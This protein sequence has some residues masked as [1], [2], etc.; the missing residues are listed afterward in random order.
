MGCNG[1]G[2]RNGDGQTVMDLCKNYELKILNTYF[3]KS[4]EK[5]ITY[6]SGGCETQIDL[7]LMRKSEDVK[8]VNCNAIP[9]EACVTQHRMV[10]AELVMKNMKRRKG[11]GHKHIKTWN[12]KNEETRE[13]E[14]KFSRVKKLREVFCKIVD[15]AK[16]PEEWRNSTT[17]PLF[18][19][20]RDA[21][22][23]EAYRG[24]TRRERQRAKKKKK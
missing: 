5:L 23:C 1:F 16:C 15:E 22:E 4:R 7:L 12:L 14:A 24:L 8:V 13:Y 10:R 21:L 9:G 19:G 11:K 20:K 3:K 6:K 2:E 18:K 17:V